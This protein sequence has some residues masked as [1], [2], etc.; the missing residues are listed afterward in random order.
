MSE[1]VRCA[2]K[3]MDGFH[4]YPCSRTGSVQEEGKNWCRTHAPSLV[5]ERRRKIS[6]ETSKRWKDEREADQRRNL[7]H[8]L[9][10]EVLDALKAVHPSHAATPTPCS[11]C[12]AIEKAGG[13]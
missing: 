11:A 4:A 1:W 7:R 9:G 8:G 10:K 6:A 13:R 12:V 2:K 3:V 5:A